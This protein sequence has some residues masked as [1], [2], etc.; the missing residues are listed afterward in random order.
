MG[1]FQSRVNPV[2][3]RIGQRTNTDSP[4]LLLFFI[5]YALPSPPVT[6]ILPAGISVPIDNPVHPRMHDSGEE[7]YRMV[8]AFFAYTF[9]PV[10]FRCSQRSLLERLG[11]PPPFGYSVSG[12]GF[13]SKTIKGFIYF[14]ETNIIWG[15]AR[16]CSPL[17]IA[18]FH[19]R[20]EINC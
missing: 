11:G 2:P 6:G 4:L 15:A 17:N 13:L 16:S 12:T 19:C 8:Y 7:C 5:C 18:L 20:G 1:F 3:K 9:V 10:R 14:P